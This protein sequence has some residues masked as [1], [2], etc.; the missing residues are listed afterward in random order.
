MSKKIYEMVTDRII[1]K[2]ENGVIPWRM[3]FQQGMAVNWNTGR[4]YR[5]INAMLL[6]AGGE[7]ATFKQIKDAGGRV[8]KGEKSQMVVFWKLLD[9]EDGESKEDKKIPLM[10]FYNVFEIN[11]QVEGLKSKREFVE[12]QHD[13]I[14][15]CEKIINDYTMKPEIRYKS[16]RAFY[17]PSMDYV[18]VPPLKD[19]KKAE[20]YYGVLFHELLHST[21]HESR[22]K[23]DG[24]QIGN[25][26]FGSETYSKEEL[27]AEI[28][29]AMLCTVT[30]IDHVTIDNSAS[31]INGWLRKL[32][33]DKKFI[34]QASA[35]AQKA[36]DFILDTKF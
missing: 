6:E 7:Y 28:G 31:Y 36:V 2:L 4:P 21:G 19:Y 12:E 5:G 20:E 30:K 10:R 25:I 15:E 24:V 34:V 22:L 16:G 13:P 17:T 9:V 33:D 3:P 27:I 11:T 18:S 14:E 32:K 26:A 35:N 8:K 23:R 1:E 29:S